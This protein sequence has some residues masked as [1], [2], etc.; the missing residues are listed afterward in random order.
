MT[1]VGDDG[2]DV[3]FV[4]SAGG[5]APPPA[6]GDNVLIPAS[7][8]PG[9]RRLRNRVSAI[10]DLLTSVPATSR[11][12]ALRHLITRTRTILGVDAVFLL[13]REH[14]VERVVASD[15]IYTH[16]FRTL[17]S[18][19]PGGIFGRRVN[20]DVP[21]QTNNYLLDP[22]FSHTEETDR[23]VRSEGLRA[24]LGVAV[25]SEADEATV[26]TLYVANR[27]DAPFPAED[28]FALNTLVTLAERWL[29]DI[30]RI[31]RLTRAL[32]STRADLAA[33]E[34]TVMLG[35]RLALAQQALV[36]A[37]ADGS[38]LAK[39]RERLAVAVGRELQ[40]ID[41]TVR[42]DLRD[43]AAAIGD[44]ERALVALSAQSG[45][46]MYASR[47][48][49]SGV[50]VMAATHR[51]ETLG[52][53]V[54]S[55]ETE[56]P[57]Q[58]RL[59]ESR[60]L[61]ECGRILGAFLRAQQQTRGDIKRRQQ[62]MLAELL[63][64]P[65]GG[66]GP[67]SQSRLAEFGIRD[68][69]PYRILVVDGSQSSV[70]TF[71][72][73]LELDFGASLLRGFV[74]E[75]LVAVMPE[76]AFEHLSAAMT[77]TGAR[78]HGNLLVGYSPKLHP[79]AII[80]EEYELLLRVVQAARAANYAQVMV[81]LNSF[82]ALGAFLSQVTIEPTKR[83]I[84]QHLQPLL[85]YDRRHGTTLVETAATYLDSG[86]SVAAAA[87]TLHVHEN[88]VRQRLDR[89]ATLMGRDWQHGQRGLD[90]HLMLT[91]HRLLGA[92]SVTA[93]DTDSVPDEPHDR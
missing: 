14:G 84:A 56:L 12:N 27:S 37:I 29:S 77:A 2:R 28:V 83:A 58:E 79:I 42:L 47:G 49:G 65:P 31:E 8:R 43:D 90:T 87:T 66:L 70:T 91:A 21:M 16:E 41:L 80:P 46:P 63:T 10:V 35:E 20:P 76:R 5:A 15:G 17:H 11:A 33:A 24:M 40:T 82:G 32:N 25:P 68:G 67:I 7:L 53:I 23:G 1:I 13:R 3:E 6:P 38:S 71:E 64:P 22:Y 92:A 45:A 34:R 55:S 19:R 54:A 36:E 59:V 48:D 75:H 4:D 52:A 72:H 88:T 78:R 51:D 57:E 9:E 60:V 30:E 86:R 50:V 62:D 69:E 44:G 73:R 81:S 89:I 26:A 39:L 18:E 93:T 74:G 85:D 61:A